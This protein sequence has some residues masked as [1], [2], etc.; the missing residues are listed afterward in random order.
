M[1][2]IFTPFTGNRLK[3]VFDY[4]FH[5]RFCID[6]SITNNAESFIKE[7]G[8]AKFCYSSKNIEESLFFYTSSTLL[9]EKDVKQ[10]QLDEGAHNGL[11]VLFSHQNKS[12]ALSFDIF[13]AVFYLI[14]RYEE[15]IYNGKDEYGNFDCRQSILYKLGKVDKPVVDEWINIFKS[16]LQNHFPS[17]KFKQ[18][19]PRCLLSFDIDVAYEYKNRAVFR[20]IGGLAKKTLTVKFKSLQ[21]HILTLLSKKKDSFDTYQYIA[22]KIKNN[23]AIFF[24]NMGKYGKRDKNPSYKNKAFRQLIHSLQ[25][26]YLVG[27]HPSYASNYHTELLAAEKQ[28]LEEIT[29][30]KIFLSRQHYLKIS[31][32]ETFKRLIQNG[33]KKDFSLGYYF[34]YGFRAGTCHSFLFFDL[35]SNEVT[36]LRLYPFAFMDGTL[37]EVM[38]LSHEKAKLHISQLIETVQK[39]NGVFIPIWH[40]ST[41]SETGIWKGW[42]K[43]FEHMLKELEEKNFESIKNIEEK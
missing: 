32:P 43:V 17:L 33:I 27:L 3:Y 15:Y 29:Q 4:I 19:K 18:E 7:T 21:D 36:D 11:P 5:E 40:N 6:Y 2:L 26:K 28:K 14:S 41:L 25:L 13:A 10:L 16:V 9:N 1:L 22:E 34:C 24:F 8:V 42:R 31:M 35:L 37:N 30:Q 39:N 38:N 23:N 12:S 20:T